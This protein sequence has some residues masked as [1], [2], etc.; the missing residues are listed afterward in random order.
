VGRQFLQPQLG[1]VVGAKRHVIVD[2]GGTA[3]QQLMNLVGT[4]G[5]LNVVVPQMAK[6]GVDILLHLSFL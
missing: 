5:D 4:G 1:Q 3:A 6:Q 2:D